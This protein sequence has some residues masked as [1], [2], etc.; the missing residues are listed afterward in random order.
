[1]GEEHVGFFFPVTSFLQQHSLLSLTR[2]RKMIFTFVWPK[3]F[4]CKNIVK[5]IALGKNTDFILKGTI[6]Q[7]SLEVRQK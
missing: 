2:R 4:A 6:L 3:Y 5:F 1:M 7:I